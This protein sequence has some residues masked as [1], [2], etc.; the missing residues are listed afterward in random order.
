MKT[1]SICPIHTWQKGNLQKYDVNVK[2]PEEDN[3]R[4]LN[5]HRD[6]NFRKLFYILIVHV[7][8]IYSDCKL[9]FSIKLVKAYDN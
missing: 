6:T 9:T 5:K 8:Q 7:T 4:F 2:F 3:R 1:E